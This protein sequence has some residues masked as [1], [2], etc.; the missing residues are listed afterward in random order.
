MNLDISKGSAKFK[1]QCKQGQP[2]KKTKM[3]AFKVKI[4]ADDNSSEGEGTGLMVQH[5]L[6]ADSKIHNQWILDSGATCHMSNSESFFVNLRAPN[7]SLNNSLTTTLGDGHTFPVMGCGDVV[8][9]MQLSH[10]K[11]SKCTLHDMLFIPDLA[12]NLLSVSSAAKR[13]KVTIFSESKCEIKNAKAKLIACGHR[14]GSLYYLDCDGAPQEVHSMCECTK[15]NTWHCRYGHLGIRSLQLL[16][17]DKM[18][19]GLDFDCSDKFNFCGPCK[20][21]KSPFQ[22]RTL[23]RVEHPVN[24]IHNDVCGKIGSKSLGGGIFCHFC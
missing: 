23:K 12:Y 7:N 17:K 14:E 13:G 19:K 18:V 4:S 3:G 16:V 20:E 24:L 21:G 15:G 5:A 1:A 8:L 22:E 11:T 10:G 2:K 6:C 9:E